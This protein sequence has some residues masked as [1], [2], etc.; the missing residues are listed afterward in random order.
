MLLGRCEAVNFFK[1]ASQKRALKAPLKSSYP[2]TI[3]DL[4]GWSQGSLKE[5]IEGLG[6]S[7]ESK[8]L[9]DDYKSD[10]WSGLK[11][12]PGEFFKYAIEDCI[13]LFE[14]DDAFRTL[15]H[16]VVVQRMGI[17]LDTSKIPHT[18]GAL[19]ADIFLRWINRQCQ[20]DDIRYYQGCELK[21]SK[22]TRASDRRKWEVSNDL[23]ELSRLK[24]ERTPI[25]ANGMRRV[26]LFDTDCAYGGIVAGGR[27]N[28]ER[29]DGVVRD[30]ILDIDMCGCYGSA[31]RDLTYPLGYPYITDFGGKAVTLKNLVKLVDREYKMGMWHA[32]IYTDPNEA[33]S[34]DQDLLVSKMADHLTVLKRVLD[35]DFDPDE[36]EVEGEGMS[37]FEL[38]IIRRELLNVVLTP[39]SLEVL[40]KVCNAQEWGELSRKV[41]VRVFTGYKDSK[42]V[43]T[44][45]ELLEELAYARPAW[46]GK[47]SDSPWYGLH[48]GGF[49][50]PLLKY[51]GELKGTKDIDPVSGA[52]DKMIKLLVNTTYGVIAS[53]YF[54]VGNVTVAN[55]ITDR[56]RCYV[57]AMAKSLGLFQ[58]I[59]DGG[60]YTP[61]S[62]PIVQRRRPGLHTLSNTS[63]WVSGEKHGWDE[64]WNVVFKGVCDDV[65]KCEIDEWASGVIADWCER[66]GLKFPYQ[67]E[68]KWKNTAVRGVFL[69][70]AHYGLMTPQGKIIYKVRGSR[71]EVMIGGVKGRRSPI[72]D[73]MDALLNGDDVVINDFEYDHVE[74]LKVGKWL[75]SSFYKDAVGGDENPILP[76]DVVV[77]KRNLHLNNLHTPIQTISDWRRRVN[78]K[79][80]HRG[81]RVRFFERFICEGIDRMCIRMINDNLR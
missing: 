57:W 72:F 47:P 32:T 10:M 23:V 64:R 76:G 75:K 11:A 68:H 20:L 39:F 18:V 77:T 63:S 6:L 53:G 33:L 48:I 43:H 17:D 65:I 37:S 59:T 49:I 78:R 30:S 73:I 79:K 40:R 9:M 5:M 61:K 58:T 74:I 52:L 22:R 67:V 27:C 71:P 16:N 29:P 8:G 60:A 21:K 28:N 69:N 51:R 1:S 62:M 13:K 66:Y 15:L 70:K 42:R 45:A 46:N 7:C 12:L 55:L 50:D 4:A 36:C 35:E 25:S 80:V 24:Y 19:V 14:V 81:V 41:Y 34:F 54:E 44:P 38:A 31:L 3:H 26:A 56:A 2:F